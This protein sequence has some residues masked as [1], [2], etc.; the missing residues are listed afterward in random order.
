MSPFPHFAKFSLLATIVSLMLFLSPVLFSSSAQN[1]TPSASLACST[2]VVAEN[3]GN[4]AVQNAIT[5]AEHGVTG[6]VVCVGSGTYPEQLDINTSGITLRGLGTASNPT[7]IA[8]TS[9]LIQAIDPD[10]THLPEAAIILVGSTSSISNVDIK[11][12]LVDGSAVTTFSST[13]CTY[14]DYFGVLYLNGSGAFSNSKIQ[15]I[16]ISSTGAFSYSC[17]QGFVS[18]FLAQSYSGQFSSVSVSNNKIVNFTQEGI[19]CNDLGTSCQ[20]SQNTIR[21]LKAATSEADASSGIQI[22]LGA[23]ATVT[24]NKISG[25]VCTT[26]SSCGSNLNTQ[27]NGIGIFAAQTATGTSI[28]N[29]ILNGNDYGIVS[30][31]NNGSI[32]WNTVN[33][34]T[35]AGIALQDGAGAFHVAHNTLS[36]NPIGAFVFSDGVTF[37]G[38]TGYFASQ[39]RKNLWGT[40]P[41]FIQIQTDSPGSAKVSALGHTYNVSGTATVNIH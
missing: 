30:Y 3:I 27:F 31:G 32:S 10:N 15:N 33:G 5:N 16:Y 14:P 38:Y 17:P 37:S 20:I 2:T 40:D 29:N 6:P 24:G 25:V 22:Y 19:T 9:V 13:S 26:Q 1:Y 35:Y 4:N 7:R 28:S 34:S 41:I 36:G 39:F 11:N 23:F 8:P 18:G 12:V 21:P